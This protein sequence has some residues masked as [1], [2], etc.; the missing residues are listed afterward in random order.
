MTGQG[1][2]AI[3]GAGIQYPAR[4]PGTAD[5]GV[6]SHAGGVSTHSRRNIQVKM[7]R[8]KF[9]ADRKMVASHDFQSGMLNSTQ[10]AAGLNSSH[11]QPGLPQHTGG[12]AGIL[13]SAGAVHES[14]AVG[15]GQH[16]QSP[17]V[18]IGNGPSSLSNTRFTQGGKR[19][20]RTERNGK[21]MMMSQDFSN[22]MQKLHDFNQR[23]TQRRPNL[24]NQGKTRNE[25]TIG[26]S[27]AVATANGG[28]VLTGMT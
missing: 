10:L 7:K 28:S 9:G 2:R 11:L 13:G 21:F 14:L 16:G 18:S 26:S 23:G 1:S 12:N 25:S 3:G 5:A 4:P 24:H 22:G 27:Y 15:A 8:K 19:N 6:G 17:N 20:R